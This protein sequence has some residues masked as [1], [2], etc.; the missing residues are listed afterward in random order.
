MYIL[1]I[2]TSC[3]D[4]SIAISNDL[5]ILANVF[6]SKLKVHND[7]GGV[8]PS[9]AKRQHDEFLA[10]AIE[11]ALKEANLTI[12]EIDI[13][14]VTYGPGL[15][16]ALESGIKKAKELAIKHN[17]KFIAVNHMIGHIYANLANDK[18]GNSLSSLNENNFEGF[19]FPALALTI[20]GG[21]TDLY[22]M[23]DHL[24]FKHIGKT[25]DDAV[26][27][28][29]DKVGRMLGMGFPAGAKI[30]Q[31]AK[32][33]N[34]NAFNFPRPLSN[35]NDFNWSYSG[36]KTAVLYEV[37]KLLGEYESKPGK[38]KF[39]FEDNS[40]KLNEAQV[41]DLAASF[42]LA[43]TESLIIKIKKALLT[44]PETKML[45]IGG[46]VIA[47]QS[48][49]QKLEALAAE[50]NIQ[51]TYPKPMWLCTDNAAMIATAAYYYAKQNL[52]INEKEIE[53]IDRVPNL[54][55]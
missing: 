46:G 5:N 34:E 7:W 22:L 14:A 47:N 12:E 40:G 13:I 8:V 29:F 44:Y 10:P 32:N 27:E 25:L 4:T 43:A 17:K 23:E 9:E 48:I 53:K 41:A 16:I 51:L 37:K 54:E 45:I 11:A 36:L 18:D 49:R 39:K 33:G 1:S 21:H 31:A 26:G 3:D 55:I 28:S 42:Q 19:K 38:N 35:S 50:F 24:K 52:Y 20:S 2:D 15:A 6:W 30:E